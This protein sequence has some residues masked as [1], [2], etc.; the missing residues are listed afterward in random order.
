MRVHAQ[1]SD[2]INIT[3]PNNDQPTTKIHIAQLFIAHTNT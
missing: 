1:K 2:S 3:M